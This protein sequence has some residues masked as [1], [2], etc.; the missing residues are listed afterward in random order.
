MKTILKI[1]TWLGMA[2]MLTSCTQE[3]ETIYEECYCLAQRIEMR[4]RMSSDGMR[5]IPYKH[6]AEEFEVS[7][8]DVEILTLT[9]RDIQVIC[10]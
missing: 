4:G 7:C 9:N 3:E 10:D 5:Y 8:D 1:V 6:V 2:V